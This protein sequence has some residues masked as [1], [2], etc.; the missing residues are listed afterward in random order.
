MTMSRTAE[1]IITMNDTDREAVIRAAAAYDKVEQ[2]T[3][4]LQRR[5]DETAAH[6]KA[7]ET[8]VNELRLSLSE[9][10]NNCATYRAEA[11]RAR[12]DS[13]AILGLLSNCK[14]MFDGFEIPS[15]KLPIER[16]APV[17]LVPMNGKRLSIMNLQAHHCRYICSDGKDP[18]YCGNVKFGCSSYC[19]EHHRIC[20]YRR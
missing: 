15:E 12:A 10:R 4:E 7:Q 3:H 14:A 6:L 16:P 5:L 20:Y 1:A 17:I 2:I 9:E 8:L 13:T 19:E 18:I 11:E